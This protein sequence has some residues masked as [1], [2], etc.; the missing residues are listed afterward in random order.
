MM[1]TKKK[2]SKPSVVK[3]PSVTTQTSKS[4]AMDLQINAGK[5]KVQFRCMVTDRGTCALK[6]WLNDRS[7]SKAAHASLDRSIDQLSHQPPQN[8]SKPNP[9]SSIGNHINVIRFHDEN[10]KQHR[11]FGHFSDSA[12]FVMT[13]SGF[14]KDRIYHPTNYEGKSG[15]YRDWCN[16]D[17][18]HRTIRCRYASPANEDEP[19]VAF[20]QECSSCACAD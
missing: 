17:N 14:E 3:A 2:P 1:T 19:D 8:W 4:P 12:S 10:R 16:K 9:A 6:V 18:E 11:I 5:L 15:E 7:L 13:L 20:H